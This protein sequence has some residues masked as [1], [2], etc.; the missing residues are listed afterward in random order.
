ME[1]LH[2]LVEV[3]IV[4]AAAVVFAAAAIRLNLGPIVGYLVGGAVI[5]P[6]LLNLVKSPELSGFL[7]EIG[8]VFLLFTIGLELPV[9]RI[10]TIGMRTLVIGV[11]QV[12]VTTAIIAW[13]AS[14]FGIGS[15]GSM[16]IGAG[17]A[18]SSTT[19][20]L[21]LLTDRGQLTSRVG[22]AVFAILMIQ[23]LL[24]GPLLV[25]ILAL[26]EGSDNLP[27]VL[28]L[29]LGKAVLAVAL[30]FAIGGRL[31]ALLYLPIAAVKTPELFTGLSVLVVL[32]VGF[33]THAAG[34]SLAFGGFLAGVLLADSVY[35]HQI[36]AD[37]R[38]FRG[39]LLGLFFVSVGMQLDLGILFDLP[40]EVLLVVASLFAIKAVIIATLGLLSGLGLRNAVRLGIMLAQ[41]GEFAF[42]LWSEASSQGLL[43]DQVSRLLIVAVAI[44]MALT[45]FLFMLLDRLAV[46]SGPSS[47]PVVNEPE[48]IEEIED[49]VVVIGCGV[50]G[51][52]VLLQLSE[53][54][55]PVLAL[56]RD[57]DKV[58]Q[59]RRHTEHAFF[60]D[61][62]QPDVL[63]MIHIERARA[64]VIALDD[65]RQDLLVVGVLRYLFLDMP[66]LARAHDEA[67]G[68]L[69]ER[70]GATS[71]IPEVID[72]GRHLVE[73]LLLGGVAGRLPVLP[74]GRD[75]LADENAT[76]EENIG[77][78]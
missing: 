60:G 18:L 38:P 73:A 66:I 17:L 51:T 77:K 44:S 68:Q 42:V 62:T 46:P 71:V 52:Q 48:S 24:V 2:Y 22:R 1:E 12:G 30:I 70:A 69:L 28:G 47:A 76:T 10:R 41:G 31:L 43:G 32:G 33:L 56:D 3:L 50:V 11:L 39:L 7:G 27:L 15:A 19:I 13:I 23:D 78:G 58:R 61:A 5:G 20:V 26:G 57:V 45:P 36:A 59:L 74:S 49:H 6:P 16:A 35:R 8:V 64:V 21:R 34:L 4:L 63:E 37:I 29:A 55:V 54:H 75:T 67:H 40:I 25:A 9:Q 72:T 14:T 53:R 65:P